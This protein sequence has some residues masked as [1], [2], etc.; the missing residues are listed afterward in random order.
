MLEGTL[1]HV[2]FHISILPLENSGCKYL[3]T[4]HILLLVP[5]CEIGYGTMAKLTYIDVQPFIKLHV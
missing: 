3:K 2:Q 5:L 1:S 4:K